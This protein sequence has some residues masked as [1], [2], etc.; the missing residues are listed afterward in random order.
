MIFVTVGGQMPFDRLVRAVDEWA[1][2]N[3][4][5]AIFAQI[6]TTELTP[7]AMP[8]EALIPPPEFRRRVQEASLV[9]SHAGM[10]T[11]LTAL[12]LRTPI[13]VLPRREHLRETRNDHQ[14]ATMNELAARGSVL[15]AADEQALVA[16]LDTLDLSTCVATPPEVSPELIA[17]I[18]DFINR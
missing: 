5:R 14:V 10:G 8:W 7:R 3:T 9:V 13:L 15:P 2:K 4:D 1:A 17:T 6:G 12:E 18:R 16:Q 11:I